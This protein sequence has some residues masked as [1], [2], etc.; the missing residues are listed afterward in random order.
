MPCSSRVRVRVRH[1]IEWFFEVSVHYRAQKMVFDAT[2]PSYFASS[3]E[4]I[5]DDGMRS[6]P[7]DV[8][9]SSYSVYPLRRL[10][11][12]QAFPGARPTPKE[13][14]YVVL[15]YLS[16]TPRLQRLY[17]ATVDHM[18]WHATHQT[19]EGSMCHPSDGEAWKCFDRM[20]PDF[21]EEPHNVRLGL[22]TDGFALHDQY[23]RII[24]V[25]PLSLHY[26]IF[27]LVCA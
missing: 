23:D 9:P 25:G 21:A 15:R 17:W 16:L 26:K 11:R 20:Y 13:V 22:Y 12:V 6:C 5:P 1:C 8:G 14:P 27:L 7:I 24:H 2:R 3:H 19:E 10:M 4:G 18:T